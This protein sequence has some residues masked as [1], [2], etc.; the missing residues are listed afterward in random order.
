MST[1]STHLIHEKKFGSYLNPL[2]L[3]RIGIY[4]GITL[5]IAASLLLP[6]NVFAAKTSTEEWNITADKIL[7]FENPRSI[8]AKGNV[9]LTKKEKLP[10]HMPKKKSAVSPW[11]ELLGEKQKKE[12]SAEE[13]ERT[14]TP[15]YRTTV[16]VN[17]DWIAYDMEKKSIKAKGH[18]KIATPEDELQ[19]KE[20]T[21]NLESETGE[22]R[23]A[24]IVREDNELHLEGKVIAKTGENTYRIRDGWAVTC[25]VK[26]GETPPWSI[27]SSNT[28]ITPGGYAVLTNA[29]FR[30][31]KVPVFY[32]PY[33]ILPIKNTRQTGLL[34]PEF[35]YSANGGFGAGIPLFINLSDSADITLYPNYF[36]KRGVMGGAEFRYTTSE[37]SKGMFSGNYLDDSL[38]DPA[39]TEYYKETGYTHTNQKRYWVRGK[40]DHTFGND[41]ISRLDV[42]IVSDEDYLREFDFGNTGFNRS[43][44]KYLDMFGRNF[45]EDK[46]RTRKNTFRLLKNWGGISFGANLLAIDD[47]NPETTAVTTT[48]TDSEGNSTTTES[49][50]TKPVTAETTYNPE[51]GETTTIATKKAATPLWRLPELDFDGTID[52]GFANFTF[53][54]ETNY[55]H[56]WRKEGVGG[57][58]IDI[59][60]SLSTPIRISPYLESR[61]KF[62]LRNTH[63]TIEEYGEATWANDDSL[64]RF[65]PELELN[66]A[67]TLQRD[68]GRHN[69]LRHELRPFVKYFY[70][71]EIDDREKLPQ[72]DSV[73]AI[74]QLNRI[75]YGVDNL[76]SKVATAARGRGLENLTTRASL[77][78]EQSYN[79]DDDSKNEPFSDIHSRLSWTPSNRVRVNYKM[80]YDVYDNDFNSHN[81]EGI[82]NWG[83]NSYIGTE[84][85]FD[86]ANDLEQINAWAQ[87]R[88][89]AHWILGG[90]VEYSLANEETN[91]ARAFISYEAQC[92][93]VRFETKYTPE[94]TAYMMFFEL[95]NI[96]ARLGID[97]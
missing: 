24:I 97:L 64:N 39:E 73:D 26:K 40:A 46:D 59:R 38:S 7:H 81:F 94:D 33:L 85:S 1:P 48:V 77:L 49:I 9:V 62:S 18:L 32:T 90:R 13:I 12:L 29:R 22:F 92:W 36:A 71:P 76:F 79:M 74:T 58:R 2:S 87:T 23:E 67:T 56:F 86:K 68:F 30:I 66:A 27:A 42:D 44:H 3:H 89:L 91:E 41:W 34:F 52:T 15:K 70:I 60:P 20:G 17:A 80:Y 21:L 63:Y 61:A 57:N 6:D 55:V 8:I 16:T 84:Y 28:R 10:L 53:D 51:T 72:W 75:T 5:S 88:L 83:N 11:G 25:K 37:Q 93:T 14:E 31:H 43:Q 78:I 54:W 47:L 95:A 35:S 82:Y 65:Y 96:G 50:T 69:P 45:E 4:G 19:A